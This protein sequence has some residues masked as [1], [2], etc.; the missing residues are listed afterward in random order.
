MAN[1]L[2]NKINKAKVFTLN[3]NY[4]KTIYKNKIKVKYTSFYN[5]YIILTINI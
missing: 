2:L 5:A 3:D 1:V 4:L